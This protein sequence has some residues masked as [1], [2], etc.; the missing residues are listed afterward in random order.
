MGNDGQRI[1]GFHAGSLAVGQAQAAPQGLLGQDIGGRRPQGND[2]VE[3]GYIP[4]FLQLVHMDDDFGLVIGFQAD[5]TLHGLVAFLAG[6]VRVDHGDTPFVVAV[7]KA[8]AFHAGTNLVGMGGVLRDDENE[9]MDKGLAGIAGENIQLDLDVLVV[10]DAVFEHDPLKLVPAEIGLAEIGP[11]R[12]RRL[13]DKAVGHRVAE[14]IVEDDILE[15]LGARADRLGRR[16]QF[17]TDDRTKLGH[18]F[19][20]GLG[21]IAVR[22]VH[23][24]DEIGQSGQIVEIGLPDI[25]VHPF[26]LALVLVDLVHVEDV[27]DDIAAEQVGA[28]N[29]A[30]FLPAIAGHDAGRVPGEVRNAPEHIFGRGLV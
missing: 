20:A 25:L 23:H 30:P 6:L 8:V 7:E 9:G 4:A 17:Q 10:A 11:R 13:L 12:H 21:A 14:P 2:G 26:D 27:D 24:Q 19:H 28:S 18:G 15:R 22:L 16:R 29:A 3:V 5:K 1:D